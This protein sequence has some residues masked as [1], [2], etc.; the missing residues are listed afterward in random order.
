LKVVVTGVMT[1]PLKALYSNHM[2][3][4]IEANRGHASGSVSSSTSL[5][6]CAEE[7][8][9]KF[10]KAQQLGI[11]IVTPEVFAGILGM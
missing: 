9:S 11:R 1:G 5:L 6:V 2:Q 4:L 3:E 10:V 8:S 7:G